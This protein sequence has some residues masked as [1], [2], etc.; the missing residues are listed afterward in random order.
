VNLI[1]LSLGVVI[2]SYY[3][4]HGQTAPVPEKI[5]SNLIE[6]Y[7]PTPLKGLMVASILAANMSTLDSS[8]NAMS[9]VFWNDLMP[10]KKSKLFKFYINVDNFI[11]TV[12]IVIMAHLFSLISGSIKIGMYFAYFSTAPLLSFFICRMM[13]SKWIKISFTSSIIILSIFTCFLGMALNHFSFE[14]NPQLSILVGILTTVGF[15][16]L[17]SVLIDFS[18]TPKENKYE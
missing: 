13:L 15:M 16:W 12:S 7:F 2:W 3:T 10:G 4:K 9:A 11:I 1:F 6:N 17:N 18:D 5:F 8:I 14:F